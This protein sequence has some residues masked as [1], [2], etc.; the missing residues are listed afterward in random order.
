MHLTSRSGG[1]LGDND[2]YGDSGGCFCKQ[3]FP[4]LEVLYFVI[5]KLKL[6]LS[7]GISVDSVPQASYEVT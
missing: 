4:K 5:G 3:A 7:E 6:C 1:R 2:I